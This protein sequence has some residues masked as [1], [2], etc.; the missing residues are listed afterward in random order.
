MRSTIPKDVRRGSNICVKRKTVF[1]YE[2]CIRSLGRRKQGLNVK[3][4]IK[5]IILIPSD[6][7]FGKKT[8]KCFNS[9]L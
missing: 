8:F 4:R 6:L 9:G 5:M 1:D 2:K 7:H 3:V